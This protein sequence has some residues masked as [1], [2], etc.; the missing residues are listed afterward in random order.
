[1]AIEALG[2]LPEVVEED[3]G[4]VAQAVGGRD[5]QVTAQILGHQDTS[6]NES[7]SAAAR[8]ATSPTMIRLGPAPWPTARRARSARRPVEIRSSGRVPF[9]TIATGVAGSAPSARR[10]SRTAAAS[11]VA[12]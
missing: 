8:A 1:R 5:L 6:A 3:D 2:P 12:M 11:L 9:S 10:R 7:R 4:T